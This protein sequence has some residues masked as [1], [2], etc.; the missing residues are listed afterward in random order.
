MIDGSIQV[1]PAPSRIR[2]Q[3]GAFTFSPDSMVTVDR[4]SR[5]LRT[6]AAS[7][8]DRIEMAS[9]VRMDL[10]EHPAA[11]GP[12]GSILY[13][14]DGSDSL[15][16]P[17]GYVL[18]VRPAG[19]QLRA[20]HPAGAFYATQTLRQLF[21]PEID[22]SS[23]TADPR[24]WVLPAVRIHD[25]PR[26]H[27]RGM[28]LDCCRHFMTVEFVKRYIDLLSY[29]KLNRFHWHL[30]EDQGWRIEIEK[31]PELTQVGAWRMEPG[32]ERYG[33]YYTR[34]Q[35]RDVVEYALERHVTVVPE[36]EMPGHATAALAAH[37]ELSCSG[38]PFSVASGW[39]IFD[40]VFCAGKDATFD[41]L[42]NVLTEVMEL[43]PGNYVHIGGDEC[44]K[45]RW[46]T[47]ADCQRR[48]ADEALEDEAGLQGYFVRRIAAFLHDRG[49][50][51]IGWDEILEGGLPP[52]A[53]VQSW[54]SMNGAVEAVTSGHDVI[55]SPISHAYFD[56]DIATTDLRKVY[57]F[58]PMPGELAGSERS[59]VLGGECNMW[60]ERTPQE[61]VDRKMFPRLL[62]MSEC[63]W[64][65]SENKG[66][67]DFHHRLQHHYQRLTELGV[68]YGAESA[69]SA[70]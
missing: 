25:S 42:Q 48:V 33:G 31:Y 36:I 64:S 52:S 65:Q 67:H 23:A 1:V 59:R 5:E 21:P 28:L 22:G 62:A 58:E 32:G 19:I 56:A 13:T 27:W 49:R 4:R 53:T 61:T 66:F 15:L 70:V 17:E 14:T 45:E 3:D 38:G 9:G 54:R 51:L 50:R 43:F 69:D 8:V 39:G 44:P 18:D 35:I 7:L 55:V 29:Y 2:I 57:S 10:A 34:S 41:F 6:V 12:A 47:C 60:T 11:D 46:R 40:D 16:G 63:L 30:T 26:F 24:G 68:D 20:S 37:P